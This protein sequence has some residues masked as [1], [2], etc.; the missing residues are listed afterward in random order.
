MNNIAFYGSHNASVAIEKDGEIIIV[1]ELERLLNFKN[2]GL[3]QY[4]CPRGEDI[5]FLNE[6]LR[7]IITT[8]TGVEEF[9]NCYFLNTDVHMGEKRY[10]LERTLRAKNYT[11]IL[12]HQAHAAGAFYQSNFEKALVFSFDGGGN[13]GF[14]NVYKAD[15]KNSV[16]LLE[17]VL[18]PNGNSPHIY[19]DLGFPYMV[20]GHYLQDIRKEQLSD[21]NLVYS[22]KL[23]G[24]ASY[25]EVKQ[26]W[27]QA[28]TEFYKSRPD[29]LTYEEGI[30]MLGSKIGIQ[31]DHQEENRIVGK[32]GWDIAATSQ[33][34]FEECFL[35]VAAPYFKQYPEHPIIVTGGCGLNI[36]LNTRLVQEFNKN[37]FVGP[38]PNDCGLAVG[39]L[40]HNIRPTKP[41]DVTYLG[42]PLLDINTIGTLMQNSHI[43][44][45]TEK[46]NLN[47]ISQDLKAGR[48]VGIARGRAEHGPRALGNRSILCNPTLPDMK[49]ILNQKV[50]NREWYRP[51]A[52]VVRLE[53]V[54]EYFEWEQESRWMSFCPKVKKEWADVLQSITHVDG[55]ARV[56]TVTREQNEWLYDLLTTFKE[57]T[58]IGVLLNTSFNVAGKPILSTVKDAFTLFETTYMD[59]LLIENYY[60]RKN[61]NDN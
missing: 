23:M 56:Q 26:E 8:L 35:E 55:T 60:L 16:K 45:K 24:L 61:F 59:S 33:R 39:M 47:R 49:D 50:K 2:S 19:Y 51:F 9:D 12:H 4:K 44:F 14:F 15:R 28:F 52:P 11:H 30:N 21:G 27:I 10:T 13:D 3:A 34:V 58:G 20:F 1:I 42:L 32:L 48:I 41:V 6:F 43:A 5:L 46:M 38:N 53:D 54:S 17:A 7:D 40:L 25:G 36:I 22:G 37:V 31:L 57:D 18:Q 29:G